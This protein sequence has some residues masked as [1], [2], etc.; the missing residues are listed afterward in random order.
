MTPAARDDEPTSIDPAI[1]DGDGVR[2]NG[3]AHQHANAHKRRSR[4]QE[5]PSNHNR[6]EKRTES[7]KPRYRPLPLNHSQV[8]KTRGNIEVGTLNVKGA[9]LE[10]GTPKWNRISQMMK[11]KG[12][13]ILALQETHLR[14]SELEDANNLPQ[15]RDS[16]FMAHTTLDSNE[17]SAGI[18]IMINKSKLPT[19]NVRSKEI[20]P[21]RAL[22]T[23]IPWRE[24]LTLSVLAVY[25]PNDAAE[26][27]EFWLKLERK[28]NPTDHQSEEG[29]PLQHRQRL[30]NVHLL[31][32]DFNMV[33]DECD[34]HPIRHD[35]QKTVE[36]LWDLKNTLR[37]SDGWQWHNPAPEKGFTFIQARRAN[38]SMS[39]IDRVYMNEETLHTSSNWAITT[40]GWTDHHLLTCK[41]EAPDTP[42]QGK[43]RWLMPVWLVNNKTLLKD[44]EMKG[45]DLLRE[46]KDPVSPR[47]ADNNP[48][49]QFK[50]LLGY[51]QKSARAIQS[52]M[53]D[54]LKSRWTQHKKNT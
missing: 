28:W 14:K 31:L 49:T 20:I 33:E 38:Q 48:Q 34:R 35:S 32:G 18:T 4:Q 15:L 44:I 52:A 53:S 8:H 40:V 7:T 24:N 30:P 13:A 51:I 6:P 37:V 27:R 25:A 3:S 11:H 12:I 43:G 19:A 10:H 50:T 39:R 21:G 42:L 54:K 2:G 5:S 22:L 47:T 46:L 45:N 16:R 1:Y 41:I 36:A 9:T 23:M 26:N 17:R 29:E